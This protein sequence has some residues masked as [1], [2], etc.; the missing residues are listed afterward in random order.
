MS[1][2]ELSDGKT[3]LPRGA[4]IAML[5]G[6]MSRDE[7][8][9]DDP[10]QFNGLRWYRSTEEEKKANPEEDYTGIESGSIIW[11]HGRFTCPGRWL[12]A[13]MIKLILANLLLHY[14]VS[15]PDGQKERPL[16]AK[17]DTEIIP[18]LSQKIVM[19]KRV[20]L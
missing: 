2:I 15:F 5:G 4:Y 19:T 8:F 9:Y 7:T 10:L 11:G 6:P 18:S 14:D 13:V 20:D 12:A 1:P 16:N 17:Y 3:V